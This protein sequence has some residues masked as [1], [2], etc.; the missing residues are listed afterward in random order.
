MVETL[1]SGGHWGIY[2]QIH[3]GTFSVS[4]YSVFMVFAIVLAVWVY[5]R[6]ARKAD[7]ANEGG[8]LIAFG[9]FAGSAIG[10]KLL[11]MLI[12]IDYLNANGWIQFLFSGRTVIGGLIGGTLGVWLVKRLIGMK[13]RR[14]NLF[15]PA[16]ALGIAVG[17]LGCFFNGCCYGKPTNLPWGVDFGDGIPRHPTQ[18]YEAVFMLLLFLFIQFGIR[19]ERAAPGML[20]NGLMIAY[21]VFRFSV[22]FIRTERIAFWGLSYFQIISI[23]VIIYLL[24]SEKCKI[25]HQI[26]D[27]GK[28]R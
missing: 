14:G 2:P 26:Y 8:F 24:L 17:R 18:L 10:A 15:A 13:E 1:K 16:V 22:E 19:K 28:Q 6:E 7:K 9:A 3:L 27:Y 21:F 20:F 25:I 23:F 12:N 4:T 5:V 11:E